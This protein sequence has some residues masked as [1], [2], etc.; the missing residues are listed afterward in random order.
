MVENRKVTKFKKR[1]TINVGHIIFLIVFIYLAISFY[2]YITKD[3]LTFYEVRRGSIAKDNVY[4]GLIIR[5]EEIFNTNKSGYI[6]YYYKDGD[7]VPKK[8]VIYSINE[9]KNATSLVSG[10][11]DSA[12]LSKAEIAKVSKEISNY[13]D[14]YSNSNFTSVYDLKYNLN[15]VA[16]EIGQ[17]HNQN[18]LEEFVATNGSENFDVV[19]SKESGVIT[20]YTDDFENIKIEDITYEHFSH[21]DYQKTLLRS[22]ELHEADSPAYKL[23][24][25]NAWDIIIP[26]N[27]ETYN[28][29]SEQDGENIKQVTIKFLQEGLEAPGTFTYYKKDDEY[30]GRITLDYYMEKFINQRFTEIELNIEQNTGLKIPISSIVDKEFYLIPHDYFTKGGDSNETGII[31]E[32]HDDENE[33]LLTFVPTE[34]F[35]EDEDYAYVNTL[36]FSDNSWI[37]SEAGERLKLNEKGTLEGV[38]N[39]NKGYAVFRRIEVLEEGEEYTVVKEGTSYGLSVYDQIALLGDTDIEQQII[40]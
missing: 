7:R 11:L 22:D 25:D 34:I 36:T 6:Y 33:L 5:D 31:L 27:E 19:D 16:L 1:R 20:Y 35:Y 10:E 8:S 13:Y 14:E 4:N 23:V 24:T 2:Y 12:D 38:Y 30:F 21:D 29:Y 26:L 3:H 32:T 9:N 39:V 17:E 15:N 37:Q 18:Y 28:Y 40:Y